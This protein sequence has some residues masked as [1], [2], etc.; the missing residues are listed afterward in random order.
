MIRLVCINDDCKYSYEVSVNELKE[1]YQYHEKCLICGSL[2]KVAENSIE[3]IVRKNIYTRAEEYINSWVKELGWDNTLDLIAK[4]K[5]SAC[6]R[7][8]KE[9]LE[10]R[11]FK[12]K[13][14]KCCGNCFYADEG[15]CHFAGEIST[16]FVCEHYKDERE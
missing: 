11:G 12:M 3:E 13:E 7:I 9:I 2:L 4:N 8:Y 15:T 1:Y 16:D 5:D 6:Y 14:K 10:K